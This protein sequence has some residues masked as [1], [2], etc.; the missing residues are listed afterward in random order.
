MIMAFLKNTYSQEAKINIF[1]KDGDVMFFSIDEIDSITFSTQDES[2]SFVCGASTIVYEGKKYNTVLIGNQCW[3]KENINIGVRINATIQQSNNGTIEKYC[4]DDDEQNCDSYGG[5]YQWDEV[6]LYQT[7][8]KTKGI[9]PEGWH[10]PTVQEFS[11]LNG[12]INS[13][14]S[15]LM[16]VGQDFEDNIATN[17]TGFSA[18]ITG[19]V[20]DGNS[21][22]SSFV[23]LFSSTNKASVYFHS[24][25]SIAN[26][27]SNTNE[28]YSVRCIRDS[29]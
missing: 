3:L 6:M 18:E 12:F 9:C 20:K 19:F 14:A 13:N 27:S 15:A 7:T 1:T 5:L 25:T 11:E 26:W 8:E 10:V 28:A 29:K 22:S 21:N 2:S 4:M 16:S 23:N 17:S 24:G